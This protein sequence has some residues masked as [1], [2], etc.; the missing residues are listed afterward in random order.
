[1][2]AVMAE[3]SRQDPAV[4]EDMYERFDPRVG[5]TPAAAQVW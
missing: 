1:M 5:M 2:V 3:W 4:I